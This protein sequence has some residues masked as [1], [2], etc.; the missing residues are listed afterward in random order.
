MRTREKAH[1][2]TFSK[3]L[4]TGAVKGSYL[5]QLLSSDTEEKEESDGKPNL[6]RRLTLILS[7]VLPAEQNKPN[8]GS[9]EI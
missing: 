2:N 3:G 4:H 9:Q 7:H 8:F 5:A 1:S 6:H